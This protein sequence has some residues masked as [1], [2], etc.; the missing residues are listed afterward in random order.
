[1]QFEL[2]SRRDVKKCVVTKETIEKGLSP[3]LV[4]E[5]ARDVQHP[6]RAESA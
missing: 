6:R 3:T 4:T 2:P 5:A 1:V